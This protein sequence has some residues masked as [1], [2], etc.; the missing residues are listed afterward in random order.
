M[1]LDHYISK[2]YLKNFYSPV[3]QNRM[4]A[5]RKSNLKPFTPDAQSICRIENGNTNQYL[6]EE[7]AI[8]EFLKGI[9]PKYNIAIGKLAK[10]EIDQECIYTIAGFVAYIIGCSPT[11]MRIFSLPLKE[12]VEAT[13]K[14]LDSNGMLPIPPAELCGTTLTEL[15]EQGKVQVSIDPKYPQAMSIAT[16]LSNTCSFGNSSWDV[17]INPFENNPFFTSDFPIAIENNKDNLV[18]NRIVPLS[19]NLA[20][21]IRPDIHLERNCTDLKFSH[22]KHETINLSRSEVVNI[23][24]LIVRCAE[25]TVFFRDDYDWIPE[26]VKRNAKFRIETKT[27]RIPHGNGTLL[28][29]TQEIIETPS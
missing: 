4:Y 18:L 17:M 3:L 28:T 1:P 14:I 20:I 9:E 5:I 16:I 19:P 7:R 10:N 6:Q 11:G 8:E 13:A 21:R 23:N 29:S 22:F 12:S 24:R 27:K 2:V 26:F 25:T 15:L